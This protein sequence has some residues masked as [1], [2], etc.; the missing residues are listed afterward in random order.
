[1]T[2]QTESFKLLLDLAV[3]RGFFKD[4]ASVRQ[5]DDTLHY[6]IGL[7]EEYERTALRVEELETKLCDLNNSERKM[8]EKS[9]TESADIAKSRF[10]G[11]I[12][13]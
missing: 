10:N 6:F 12:Q 5:M 9:I 4:S 2:K 1:M 13:T 11:V 8:P 7:E 3:Q